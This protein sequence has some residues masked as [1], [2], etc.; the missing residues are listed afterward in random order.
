M[1]DNRELASLIWLG[2]ALLWGLSNDEIRSG[3][4]GVLR[5]LLTPIIL[6]PLLLM[7]AYIGL[8]VR[9]GYKLDLWRP[10]LAKGTVLWAVGSAAVLFFTA[11]NAT[12]DSEFLRRALVG[13]PGV[14]AFVE[15][16]MNLFAMNLLAELALQGVIA[17]LVVCSITAGRERGSISGLKTVCD[18]LLAPLG[19][20]LF[21]FMAWQ[22]QTNWYALDKHLLLLELILPS[23]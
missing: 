10:E 9:I 13:V 4:A 21:G 2:I 18:S 8:E 15:F 22:L 12:T 1:L 23:G 16:F 20:A 11:T 19:F 6:L 3:L 17:V 5:A 7:T 14:T